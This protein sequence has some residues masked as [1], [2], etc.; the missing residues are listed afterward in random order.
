M[1]QGQE[2]KV[3]QGEAAEHLVVARLLRRGYVASQVPE[4]VEGSRQKNGIE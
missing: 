2:E 4:G 1:A 3:L